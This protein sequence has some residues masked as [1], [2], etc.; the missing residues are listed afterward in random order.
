[1]TNLS[2]PSS[3]AQ[4]PHVALS[5][6]RDN[7]FSDSRVLLTKVFPDWHDDELVLK[8]FKDG[9]TNNLV[10]CTNQRSGLAV[11]IRA[12]GNNTEV[13][14]DR[15]QE[16]A[17]MKRLADLGMCPPLYARFDNGLVYGYIPG[18]VATA[19][20]MGNSEWAPLIARQLA[21][22]SQVEI[23]GD[24]TPCLFPVLR[25]WLSDVPAK[26]ANARADATFQAH[27]SMTM[28]EQELA[29]LEPLLIAANSPVVF[30]HNDLL[31]GNIIMSESRTRVSF[32]DYEYANYNYRGFDIANHFCEY[33]GFE[34]DYTRY[35]SK[36]VQIA[37]FKEYLGSGQDATPEACEKLF[38]EVR[39]FELASHYYWGVWGL[40]QASI[41][42]ID[43]DYMEYARMRFDQYFKVKQQLLA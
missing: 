11:L 29:Y 19:E 3:S 2:E 10:K 27:F 37:W 22:W 17:N 21:E 15:N 38:E 16:L 28:L 12:Y 34:C 20:T 39:V 35:P 30:A 13:I 31:S 7:L 23:P 40:V 41:S 24:R 4:V 14:I 5:V 43:F 42:E 8:E 33:A 26:Y 25:Q 9:I 36:Q 6:R 18:T 32:I 1:M